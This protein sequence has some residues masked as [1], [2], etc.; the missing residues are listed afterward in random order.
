MNGE[1]FLAAE[2]RIGQ[3]VSPEYRGLITDLNIIISGALVKQSSGG[4]YRAHIGIANDEADSSGERI[5]VGFCTYGSKSLGDRTVNV[6]YQGTDLQEACKKVNFR[7]RSKMR[8]NRSA[9]RYLPDGGNQE[10]AL[11]SEESFRQAFF[12]RDPAFGGTPASS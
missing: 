1:G 11:I 12:R 10:A 5:I 8:I 4:L 7:M 9:E 2:E 3:G 6:L